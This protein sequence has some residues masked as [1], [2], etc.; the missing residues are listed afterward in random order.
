MANK[1]QSSLHFPNRLSHARKSASA[2]TSLLSVKINTLTLRLQVEFFLFYNINN[3]NTRDAY[4]QRSC[5]LTFFTIFLQKYVNSYEIKK[6]DSFSKADKK[7]KKRKIAVPYKNTKQKHKKIH[8]E[9]KKAKK[10]L[11]ITQS[12]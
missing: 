5:L 4:C 2:L 11:Q 1:N 6:K 12:G 8:G 3:Y 10:M 9:T 7:N